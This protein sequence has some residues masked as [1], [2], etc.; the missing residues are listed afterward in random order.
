M[1]VILNKDVE[2]IGRS[3]QLV[4]VKDGY[5]RNYLFPNGLAISATAANLKRIEQEKARKTTQ[6]EKSKKEALSLSE[7]LA[8]CSLTIAVLVQEEEKLFGSVSAQDIQRALK[9]EGF[10]IDKLLIV[11]DEP[12]K[13]LGIYEV[14]V[15]LHPEVTAKVKI[16]VVKK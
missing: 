16:W 11:L 15:A 12:I 14:S 2:R 10:E 13:Q 6:M 4:K 5:A 3:G 7:K 8:A 9:D 1:K